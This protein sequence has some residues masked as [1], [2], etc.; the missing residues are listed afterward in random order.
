MD[1]N[2]EIYFLDDDDVRN[3]SQNSDHRSPGRPGA[4]R[5]HGAPVMR[6]RSPR[7]L[8][9]RPAAV[10]QPVQAVAPAKEGLFANVSTGQLVELATMVI[11]AVMP[12]PAA[13]VAVGVGTTDINNQLAYTSALALH[14]KRDE[15]LRTIGALVGN[16]VGKEERHGADQPSASRARCGAVPHRDPELAVEPPRLDHARLFRHGAAR[17]WTWLVWLVLDDAV[18]PDGAAGSGAEGRRRPG[19]AGDREHRHPPRVATEATAIRVVP[20]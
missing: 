9:A 3:R 14:A 1:E 18:L 17:C 2:T 6:S 5:V 4:G 7:V 8:V 20:L 19:L 11:A 16:L 13:P 10:A 15:Q 12:L